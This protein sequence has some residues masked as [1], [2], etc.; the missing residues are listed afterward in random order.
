[1]SKSVAAL[2]SWLVERPDG[3]VL[4]VHV[5][6]GARGAAAVAGEHGDAL[7]IRIDSPAI[8]GRANQALIAFLAGRLGVAKNALSLL[9]GETSRRK[10]L[11]VAGLRAAELCSRLA[12][13]P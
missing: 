12:P 5:Q 3:C 11:L 6:P 9:S 7:K 1:M 2:P 10:R 4:T 13:A 8:E